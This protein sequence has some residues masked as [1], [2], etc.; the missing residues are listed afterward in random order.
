ME[1][2]TPKICYNCITN[3]KIKIMLRTFKNG[4]NTFDTFKAACLNAYYK[5]GNRVVEVIEGDHQR[6]IVL[7]EPQTAG[8]IAQ[9]RFYVESVI[10]KLSKEYDLKDKYIRSYP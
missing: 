5:T 1:L 3:L 7:P 6:T 9:Q 10:D 4:I 8:T 2:Y